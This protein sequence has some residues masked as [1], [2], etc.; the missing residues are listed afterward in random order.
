MFANFSQNFLIK[1]YQLR[2]VAAK[3]IKDIFENL[4]KKYHFSVSVLRF[5]ATF[6]FAFCINIFNVKLRMK[7][8]FVLWHYLV[9]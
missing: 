8:E 4:Y 3:I 7:C 2:N 6:L 1:R 9:C 5:F